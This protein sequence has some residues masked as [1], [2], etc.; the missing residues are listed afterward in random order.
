MA[1]DPHHFYRNTTIDLLFGSV[2]KFFPGQI[3]GV[4]LSGCLGDGSLGLRAINRAGGISMARTPYNQ[5]IGDMPRNAI[6][7]AAPLHYVGAVAE[8][9][10]EIARCLHDT[11]SAVMP[12]TRA[13][14]LNAISISEQISSLDTHQ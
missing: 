13:A 12:A 7:R 14:L 11:Q 6:S 9:S 10:R 2:A 8:L 3:L 1:D 4:V 5:A